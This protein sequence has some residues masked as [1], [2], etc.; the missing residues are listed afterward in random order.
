MR[1][2]RAAALPL[3]LLA[4]AAASVLVADWSWK[5]VTEYRS[6]YALDR[7][8]EAGEPLASRVLLVVFDGLRSDR[9][10]EL[11]HFGALAARGASGSMRV[12]IPSLSSPARAALVTGASP[13]VSGLTNNTSYR[14]P[15]VQSLLSL[16][17]LRGMAT[18]VFG[19]PFWRRTFGDSIDAFGGPRSYPPSYDVPDLVDW[20]ARA[21]SDALAHL[22]ESSA[23]LQVVGLLAG[24]DAGHE[25]G[26]ESDEYR[27]VTAAVDECLGRLAAGAGPAATVVAVSDHGHIHRWGKGG[28][29]GEEPEVLF[30]PFAMA[31]PGIRES[32]LDAARILD[33]APTVSVLLGLPIPAN[34]QGSVLW[35]AL[36]VPAALDAGLRARER[37][38]REALLAHLPDREEGLAAQRRGRLP[39]GLAA[40]AWFLAV[41]VWAAYGQR[42]RALAVGLAVFAGA[43]W[44]LFYLFQLGYS[45]SHVVR[46]EYLYWFFARNIAAA[47]LAFAAS[48][49]CMRRL[50]PGSG[51]AALRHA[52]LVTSALAL[53]VAATYLGDGLF[54]QG[55][56]IEIGPA[57]RAYLNMLAVLGVVAGALALTAAGALRRRGSRTS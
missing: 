47:G 18:S 25:Y 38:Q 41:A 29:G 42:P 51:P 36:D 13:E 5:S 46:Q 2:W 48:V 49:L 56:M 31:G 4:L 28:H 23:P 33:I 14:A 11:P 27:A 32:R 40:C 21:C 9:A 44:S 12:V 1:S 55:W 20:Q 30:A 15:S 17:R 39:T 24:D 35:D 54:M 57:F 3:Y 6:A 53:M 26:G 8:F 45:I 10:A 19:T 37:L 43:Y 34:S 7:E 16:A 52:A 50:A 22:E